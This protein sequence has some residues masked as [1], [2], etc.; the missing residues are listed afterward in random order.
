M[1]RVGGTYFFLL[2]PRNEYELRTLGETYF[3]YARIIT[4]FLAN[5][6]LLATGTIREFLFP[7]FAP[8]NAPDDEL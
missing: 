6:D 4:R 3:N 7:H 5:G 2:V 1:H 8:V